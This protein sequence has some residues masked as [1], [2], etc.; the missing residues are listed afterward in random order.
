[1]A[2]LRRPYIAHVLIACACSGTDPSA[3]GSTLEGVYTL[4]RLSCDNNAPCP[5]ENTAGA[6]LARGHVW[7]TRDYA[8]CANPS[9]DKTCVNY[10]L[11][12][13]F[14]EAAF[15]ADG[16]LSI[17]E[18][19]PDS[20]GTT[21]SSGVGVAPDESMAYFAYTND[22]K[23]LVIVQ[24]F[25]GGADAGVGQ[26]AQQA[27][28]VTGVVAD[29]RS[30]VVGVVTT[31][32]SVGLQSEQVDQAGGGGLAN[33]GPGNKTGGDLYRVNLDDGGVTRQTADF[34]VTVTHHLIAS[35]G[36]SIYGIGTGSVWVA[37]VD[38][39]AAPAPVG[40]IP[41]A[42]T[43]SACQPPNTCI[44]AGVGIDVANGVVAWSVFQGISDCNGPCTLSSPSC[45][46]WKNGT[47]P[48]QSTRIYQNTQQACLGLAIDATY[49]YF[50]L[51]A[52]RPSSCT[53]CNTYDLY[54]TGIARVALN[55][56]DTQQ[57]TVLQLGTTRLFGPRRF[58]ADDTY[59]YGIDPAYVLRIPKSAF[60][61]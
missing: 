29:G 22:T 35:S 50:A 44:S 33:G 47:S 18:Q 2:T 12:V 10:T 36:G 13:G 17:I 39:S 56:L 61:P 15:G 3:S 45:S 55:G 46:V 28:Y 27:G 54:T 38:L 14:G 8:Y 48:S 4:E 6:A 19:T 23:G 43:G 59:V 42:Q 49:A 53:G 52:E 11:H 37:P 41:P 40:Q 58:F 32:N 9:G 24:G 16:G 57:A 60:G 26:I 30:A 31:S 5:Q 1:M 20:Q 7:L 21:L 51:V 25:S 34:D